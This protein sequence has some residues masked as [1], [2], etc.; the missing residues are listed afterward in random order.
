MK[1]QES[2]P[3]NVPSSDKLSHM[4]IKNSSKKLLICFSIKQYLLGMFLYDRVVAA[5]TL[6]C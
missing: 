1:R 5:T 3:F 2:N 6:S 4:K